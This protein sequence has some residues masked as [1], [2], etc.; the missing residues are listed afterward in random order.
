MLPVIMDG[1]KTILPKHRKKGCADMY[2]TV[3]LD[4]FM[5]VFPIS[6][7]Q[8]MEMANNIY[9]YTFGYRKCASGL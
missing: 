3:D 4:L 6:R 5:R 9:C 7:F 1:D 2:Q 8:G